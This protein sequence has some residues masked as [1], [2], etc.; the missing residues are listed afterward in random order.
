MPQLAGHARAVLA[1]L[2][3]AVLL[4]HLWLANSVLDT[5]LGWGAAP[6]RLRRMEVSFV[7]E[8]APAQVVAPAPVVAPPPA[9]RAAIAAAPAA[10]TAAPAPVEAV[11]QIAPEM[12]TAAVDVAPRETVAVAPQATAGAADAPA[13]AALASV[14]DAASAPASAAAAAFD[15][16]P[17]TQLSYTLTGNYRGEVQ[18]QARVQWLKSGSRYQ[19]HLDVSIGPAFAPLLARRMSSEGEVTALGLRPRRYE[20]ETRVAFRDP[21]MITVAFDDERVRLSNNTE[22]ALPAGVQDSASQFVQMTWMFTLRPELLEVG[23]TVD[24]PLALPRRVETWTYEVLARETL[25]TPAGPV[26]A[27]HV[28]PRREARAGGDLTAEM[29]VA[30]QLQY[31]PVRIVIRQDAETYIDLLIKQLPQQA[32]TPRTTR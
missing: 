6:S 2:A 30:P 18:G 17:S 24:I 20:E 9:R 13:G 21:R 23:R 5:T 27:V 19:V 12:P 7:R 3:G 28:K 25:N 16:P 26:E 29:W 8:L 1:A 31:L 11:A 10:S 15:W 32:A 4:A 22:V 14:P